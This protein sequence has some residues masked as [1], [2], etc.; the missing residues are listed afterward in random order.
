MLKR[1]LRLFFPP[2][3]V[4]CG[5]VVENERFAVCEACLSKLTYNNRA[6]RICGTPLDTVFGDLICTTCRQKRRS[7]THAYVPFVYKDDVRDSILGMK[8]RGKRGRAITFASFIF[9]KMQKEEAPRPDLITYVPMHFIRL[10]RR[11]YNQAHLLAKA[12]GEMLGIPVLATLRKTKHTTPQSKLRGKDRLRAL[13]GV[14]VAKKDTDV[15]GKQI[16]LIDDVITTGTT[17]HACA[18][19]LKKAGAAE[20]RIATVAATAFLH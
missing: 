5:K 2:K 10:G 17:L 19:E 11:G 18:R 14:Y 9:L 13:H 4:L 16:L 20:I 7:F 1:L 3:C 8:F 15:T 6:C 12:L